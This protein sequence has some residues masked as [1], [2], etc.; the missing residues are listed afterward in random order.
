VAIKPSI[1]RWQQRKV[2]ADANERIEKMCSMDNRLQ[3]VDIATP[4]LG[5]DG[6]PQSKLFAVD[7][8]HLSEQGYRLWT[9]IVSAALAIK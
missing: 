5:D 1:A 8:L 7:G 6:K 3:Y 9:E 4:M 2:Q